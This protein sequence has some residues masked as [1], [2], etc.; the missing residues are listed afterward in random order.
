[1]HHTDHREGRGVPTLTAA[2]G[3]KSLP[4]GTPPT[5]PPA[6][7]LRVLATRLAGKV[8]PLR[9]LPENPHA[10]ND[11]QHIFAERLIETVLQVRERDRR[12]TGKIV[13]GLAWR[14]AADA[15]RRLQDAYSRMNEQNR[16]WI[17]HIK[18]TQMQFLAGEIQDVEATILNLSA[19]LHA[20]AGKTTPILAPRGKK[21]ALYKKLGMLKPRVKDQILREL[22]FGLLHAA[23]D[24]GG[25]LD[26]NKNSESGALAETLRHLRD[27]KYLPPGLV[28]DPLP[29]PT[30][31]RLKSEFSRLTS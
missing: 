29:A 31:Q 20:A 19:L 4:M 2:M 7:Q 27:G 15:A 25:K 11:E 10:R 22:V 8:V 9:H 5:Y 24:T 1:L 26:F 21:H 28:P 6:N 23:R 18:R 14:Q 12:S 13:A 16:N 30:I 3:L 17:E